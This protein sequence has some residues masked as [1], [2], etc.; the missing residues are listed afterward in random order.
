MS[1][2]ESGHFPHEWRGSVSGIVRQL[3]ELSIAL[4]AKE[5]HTIDLLQKWADDYNELL[6]AHNDGPNPLGKFEVGDEIEKDSYGE[7]LTA[8]VCAVKR[9]G[10][11]VTSYLGS[12]F[13]QNRDTLGWKKAAPKPKFKVGQKIE[14]FGTVLRAYYGHYKMYEYLLDPDDNGNNVYKADEPFI[15][16]QLELR[17]S[18][19]PQ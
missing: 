11:E 3:R 16:K 13:L 18:N 14:G 4:E 15:L 1:F 9:T 10:Y 7:M 12:H 19:Q 6:N 8:T 17:Q 5:S 2:N